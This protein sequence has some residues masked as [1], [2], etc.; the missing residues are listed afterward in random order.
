[1]IL[2]QHGNP[3]DLAALREP[4]TSKVGHL[5]REFDRHPARGLT[6]ARLQAILVQA[7]LGNL[8]DQLELADDM[9]ERDGHIYAEVGKRKGAVSALEWDIHAPERA[10]PAEEALAAELREWLQGL[11]ELSDV[12]HD[13]MDGVLKGYAMHELVWSPETGLGR[14]RL[15]PSFTFRPQRWFTVAEDR[16]TLLLRSAG[17]SGSGS[18][19]GLAGSAEPLQPFGWLAHQ[20]KARSGYATR[21]SLARVLAWPYLFK[22]YSV[23]DLAEFLEI[24][25]LP[26]RLGKYPAGASDAE[27][28][29]LLR[30]VVGIGHNAA[31][32]IPAG[33]A[34]DFQKAAEGSAMPFTAMWDRMESIQSRV[35][36]GQTLT[37]SEG[38]HGTQAL[39]TVHNEVRMDIRNADARQ[40]ERTINEQLIRAYCL[41]NHGGVVAPQR[42]P[43]FAFD[44]GEAEDLALYAEKLPLL[45]QA[46][47]RIGVDWAHKKLRIP[48]AEDGE[49]LL[50]APAEKNSSAEPAPSGGKGNGVTPAPGKRE[51]PPKAAL[52][53]QLPASPPAPQRDAIDELVDTELAHWRPMLGP[54]MQPLLAEIDKALA[55]GESLQA[56]AARL[57]ELGRRMDATPLAER[58]AR[59]AFSARLAGEAE[60]DLDPPTA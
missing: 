52:A 4:Q 13:M 28:Q 8:V 45:A 59:A 16:N 14:K 46:G 49:E 6:P 47:L 27:K 2:D 7:E 15:T 26:L 36:L 44:T 1:M 35:I 34:I 40:V 41:I 32:I 31:G 39:A 60:L 12:L 20:P 30:A 42:L 48:K 54:L 58:L 5:T 3:V 38:Q 53:A 25:G 37:A 43:R 24:F 19:P 33:M 29:A 9:E 50:R 56:F 51:A 10:T 22:H 18:V 17:G 23:R 21:S 57:P 55:A 11:P